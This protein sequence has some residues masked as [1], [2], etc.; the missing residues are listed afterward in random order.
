VTLAPSSEAAGYV[1]QYFNEGYLFVHDQGKLGKLCV[2]RND[3]TQS[4]SLWAQESQLLLDNIGSSACELLGFR[5]VAFVRIQPDGE[6]ED[7]NKGRNVGTYVRI[8]EPGSSTEVT[9][10]A[11]SCPSKKVLYVGCNHLGGFIN[12]TEIGDSFKM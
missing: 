6:A 2:E 12:N 5:K 1:H 4:N 3:S 8:Q 10:S 11:G 9:F 7:D